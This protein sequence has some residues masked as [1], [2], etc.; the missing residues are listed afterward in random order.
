MA[1]IYGVMGVKEACSFIES[2]LC[3]CVLLGAE[4]AVQL[5]KGLPS[6]CV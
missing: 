3:V 1:G 6:L 2:E 4:K 5:R